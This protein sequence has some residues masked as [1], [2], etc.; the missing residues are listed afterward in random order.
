MAYEV[1]KIGQLIDTDPARA[2]KELVQ[3]F[4]R[5][6]GNSVHAALHAGVHHATLKRWTNKL[7]K[8]HGVKKKL[9]AIRSKAKPRNMAD[10]T[11]VK[12][13]EK[14][15]ERRRLDGLRRTYDRLDDDTLAT[16]AKKLKVKPDDL[17][18][19]RRHRALML[20]D[21]AWLA[22]KVETELNRV[23]ERYRKALRD[24]HRA[25]N[26]RD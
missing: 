26:K 17:N 14:A 5:T 22:T 2:A 21:K 6:N 24:A 23:Q 20:K 7:D 4:K 25:K 16:I 1:T 18:N 11:K 10:T 9:E 3:L 15:Q 13:E 19:W 8:D 12:L